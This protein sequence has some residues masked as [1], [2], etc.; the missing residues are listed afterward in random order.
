MTDIYLTYS[1]GYPSRF[2]FNNKETLN[3][4]I[5]PAEKVIEFPEKNKKIRY[6]IIFINGV[7]YHFNKEI[8]NKYN[9]IVYGGHI[10]N[11]NTWLTIKS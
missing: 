11:P 10:N 6:R 8:Y 5:G 1:F 3:N 4:Q 7:K 9:I 2:Q